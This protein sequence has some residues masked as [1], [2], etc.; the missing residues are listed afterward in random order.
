MLEKRVAGRGSPPRQG[1]N[2][3]VR[4]PIFIN[5]S[6][7]SFQPVTRELFQSPCPLWRAGD[8]PLREGLPGLLTSRVSAMGSRE[9][10]FK[11][12]RWLLVCVRCS[13]KQRCNGSLPK[14]VQCSIW[15]GFV[16]APRERGLCDPNT[17]AR[18]KWVC[19]RTEVTG[20]R[21]ENM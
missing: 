1:V 3:S 9:N 21:G 19:V 4:H 2:M 8:R 10:S 7:R 12:E 13:P 16:W 5:A 20:S 6:Q 11:S 14:E 18:R 15:T 17:L